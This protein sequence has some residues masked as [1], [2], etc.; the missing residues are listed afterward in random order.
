M[1]NGN[2]ANKKIFT[3]Q[4]IVDTT[5]PPTP[6]L[7]KRLIS[8]GEIVLFIGRQKEGKSILALQLAIDISRGE[9]FLGQHDSTKVCVF[10]VD[11][12]NRPRN[13]QD[14]ASDLAGGGNTDNVFVKAYEHLY[15][16][17]VALF[18]PQYVTLKTELGASG[19]GILFIDP[20]RYA[21]NKPKVSGTTDEMLAVEAID[22][23]SKLQQ[24]RP[25]L[26]TILIHHLKKRQDPRF[27]V[28]L[29][30][31]PYSWIDQI[32]GSQ[33][34]LGHVDS[35]WG[36]EKDGN[37]YVFATVSRSHPAVMLALE[38]Q[39]TSERFLLSPQQNLAFTS[40]QLAWWMRLPNDFSFTEAFKIIGSSNTADRV[41]R[42][43]LA[44][45]LLTQ[46][47]VTKR[48]HKTIP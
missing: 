47:Q 33:A 2:T 42:I 44:H 9:P 27:K 31:D 1:S 36:L 14:R 13:L 46:D 26:A 7:V 32:Y 4:D 24:Q 10:Y 37:G 25:S 39:P 43:A 21:L 28:R 12:E 8:P 48:Y 18:G 20:L 5:Y 11:Y 40:K 30:K 19:A 15:Q 29:Q 41:I 45:G 35:I 34:L 38:K 22:Q 17:D 3:L 6:E 23:V 16:R